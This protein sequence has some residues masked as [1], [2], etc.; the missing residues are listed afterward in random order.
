MILTIVTIFYGGQKTKYQSIIF[1]VKTK[2]RKKGIN[3]I[4]DKIMEL[5]DFECLYSTTVVELPDNALP[6]I[7]E[8]EVIYINFTKTDLKS[9]EKCPVCGRKD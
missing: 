8:N 7:K 2:T 1:E 3:L 6:N 4:N 9:L 5:G